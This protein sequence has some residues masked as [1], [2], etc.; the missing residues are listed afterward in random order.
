MPFYYYLK[1]HFSY[2]SKKGDDLLK[3][4]KKNQMHQYIKPDFEDVYWL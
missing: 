3:E 1:F 4:T 2:E